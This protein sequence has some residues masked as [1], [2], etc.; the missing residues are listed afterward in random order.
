MFWVVLIAVAII[1]R[2]PI[3]GPIFNVLSTM[4]HEFGHAFLGILLEGRAKKIHLFQNKSGLADVETDSKV[5]KFFVTLI[6]YPSEMLFAFLMLF[7]FTYQHFEWMLYVIFAIS[8]FT[9]CLIRNW[10]G[11]FWLIT[12][13][14]INIFVFLHI[15]EKWAMYYFMLLV[16]ICVLESIYSTL[17]ILYISVRNKE[18]AG[19]ALLLR[20]LTKL[21][22]LFWGFFFFIC[23]AVI[24]SNMFPYLKILIQTPL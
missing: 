13:N 19:D 14:G 9:L 24:L 11:L 17:N 6:G 12:F 23:N 7:L 8:L 2:I 5:R 10:Y 21:P 16:L 3:V 22:V 18:N 4:F 20:K 15:H 1:V